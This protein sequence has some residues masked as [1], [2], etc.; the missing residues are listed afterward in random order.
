ML[1]MCPTECERHLTLNSDRYD[2]YP[3]VNPAIRDC[4]E[5]MRHKSDPMGVAKVACQGE[6]EQDTEWD[7]SHA[8]VHGT[9]KGKTKAKARVTIPRVQERTTAEAS[10][11]KIIQTMSRTNA[12]IVGEKHTRLRSVVRKM[13]KVVARRA[14]LE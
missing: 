13:E 9:G 8:I 7:E 4:V 14:F 2:T 11:A 10:T 6:V 3:N 1:D 5:Q 12:K